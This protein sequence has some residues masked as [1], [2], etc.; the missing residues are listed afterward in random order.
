MDVPGDYVWV[1]DITL[2]EKAMVLRQ[3]EYDFHVEARDRELKPA[4]VKKW[5][6]R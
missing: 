4:P 2:M 5:S 6:F 1:H 3:G